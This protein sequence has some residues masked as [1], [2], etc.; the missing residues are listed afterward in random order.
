MCLCV[1]SSS[2]EIAWR[3]WDKG[4][5]SEDTLPGTLQ[6]W[7]S[8]YSVQ[9]IACLLF[10]NIYFWLW[11]SNFIWIT[12]QWWTGVFQWQGMNTQNR[13]LKCR[14]AYKMNAMTSTTMQLSHNSLKHA[15]KCREEHDG[16]FQQL[17]HYFDCFN[18]IN[19]CSAGY[20]FMIQNKWGKDIFFSICVWWKS[21]KYF[22]LYILLY[23]IFAATDRTTQKVLFWC[24][25]FG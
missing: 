6:A 18:L 22:H 13:E 15:E 19:S 21:V 12:L 10:N 16:H 4:D 24:S 25:I 7:E 23:T 2:E 17:F 20:F 11:L 5:S 14:I 3:Q 9:K 1:H 8:K